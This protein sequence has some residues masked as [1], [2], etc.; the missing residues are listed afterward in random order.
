MCIDVDLRTGYVTT[1][2]KKSLLFLLLLT[3][4]CSCGDETTKVVENKTLNY[5]S[6]DTIG[7]L[8]DCTEENQGQM[9]WVDD[10]SLLRIC[11]DEKWYAMVSNDSVP[12]S[13]FSCFTEM[14]EDSSGYT[15]ICNG[16]SIGFVRNGKLDDICKLVG[17][18]RVKSAVITC[19][20]SAYRRL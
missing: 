3:F 1:N 14:N 15:V 11:A 6:Y 20:N 10:E 4:L 7:D 18:R 19:C 9:A 5:E 12:K 2:T 17:K 13:L 16:D 8:P